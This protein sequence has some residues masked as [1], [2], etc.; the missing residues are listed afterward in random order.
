M[1]LHIVLPTT[2]MRMIYHENSRKYLRFFLHYLDLQ[3]E[4][5]YNRDIE[6]N[7]LPGLVKAGIDRRDAF[8][9]LFF[10][11]CVSAQKWKFRSRIWTGRMKYANCNGGKDMEV[12]LTFLIMILLL[13]GG[14]VFHL[15]LYTHGAVH[16]SYGP[17]AKDMDRDRQI[18]SL[19]F[20]RAR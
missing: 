20:Q 8:G 13:I 5:D 6:R 10:P 2:S 14:M 18:E 15:Y 9:E 19:V 7:V 4:I 3:I 16:S 1:F 12:L 11:V 17:S